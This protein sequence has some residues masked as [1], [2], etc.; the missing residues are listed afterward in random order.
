M[1]YLCL[2]YQ[3]EKQEQ[4]V[5]REQIEQAKK[6]YWAFT[7]DIKKS[8]HYVGSNGD[9]KSTRLNSSHQITTYAV[10]CLK[11]KNP[12]RSE[13][14]RGFL[15]LI[16]ARLKECARHAVRHASA[17]YLDPLPQGCVP[18]LHVRGHAD[19]GTSGG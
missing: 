13:A 8:G 1:K 16:P 14:S 9:R 5:P 19:A 6:D 11:K 18:A 2:V 17:R 10:F 12:R 4:N 7:E 15:S 3:E